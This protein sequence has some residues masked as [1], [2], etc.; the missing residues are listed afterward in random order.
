MDSEERENKTLDTQ[1]RLFVLG[2]REKAKLG[3]VLG[4]EGR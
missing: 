2:L 1:V 4:G 3:G